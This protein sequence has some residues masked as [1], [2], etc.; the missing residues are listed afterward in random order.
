M[1]S[2]RKSYWRR[3]IQRHLAIA[4]L[5]VVLMTVIFYTM[6]SPNTVFRL[7]M[8]SAYVGLGFLAASLVIGPWKVLSGRPNPVSTD[9]RRDIGI[10]AGFLGIAHMIIGLQVHMGGK[11]WLYFLYPP[12]QHHVLPIRYD[13]FG[14]ANFTGLFASLVLILLLALSNDLSLRTLGTKRWKA[15]QRWN[16]AGFA[17]M[18]IHGAAYQLI[19]KRQ[20]LFVALFV[21]IILVAVTIQISGFRSMRIRTRRMG[22]TL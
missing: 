18:A 13:P 6:S 20:L 10:W 7:S 3:R 4:L 14:F 16:Y 2:K 9:L 12:T 22:R 15:L 5:A 17:L 11:F 8:A 21:G 19:E 1:D